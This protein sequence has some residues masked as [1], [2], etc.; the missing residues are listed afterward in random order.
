MKN[1]LSDNSIKKIKKEL[2]S[3]DLNEFEL[4]LK[5]TYK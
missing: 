1:K 4:F 5:D 3:S 2:T